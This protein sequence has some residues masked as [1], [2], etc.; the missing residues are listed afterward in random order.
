MIFSSTWLT[1]YSTSGSTRASQSEDS[2]SNSQGPQDERRSPRDLLGHLL[3]Y[4]ERRDRGRV[5]RTCP[6]DREVAYQQ[7]EV[8]HSTPASTEGLWPLIT[9]AITN[10]RPTAAIPLST[11]ALLAS[12]F[13]TQRTPCS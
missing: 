7:E 4:L 8:A 1:G 9:E 12:K 10:I 13:P 3:G 5:A 6:I 11:R 2:W